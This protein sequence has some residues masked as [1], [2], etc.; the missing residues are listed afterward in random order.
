MSNGVCN[1]LAN[2]LGTPCT[3]LS[4][5]LLNASFSWSACLSETCCITSWRHCL[6]WLNLGKR[7]RQAA[8]HLQ[9]EMKVWEKDG[10][11]FP[12]LIWTIISR[13]WRHKMCQ[14]TATFIYASFELEILFRSLILNYKKKSKFWIINSN[15]HTYIKE[16]ISCASYNP[17]SLWCHCKEG[18]LLLQSFSSPY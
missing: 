14:K 16:D 10:P 4:F 6:P 15:F 7:G 11:S 17:T 3:C 13:D 2:N 1:L 18:W 5:C 12:P 8:H 9:A